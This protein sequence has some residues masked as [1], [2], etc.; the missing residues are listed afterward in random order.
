ME[1][2]KVLDI[3]RNYHNSWVNKNFEKAG[4]F[5]AENL[6]VIVPINN[7]PTKQS[8]LAAV[9][10]TVTMV[11]SIELLSAFNN[12]NEAMIMYDMTLNN[13]SK[14]RIAEH[15]LIRDEKIIQICQIHDTAPFVM[16]PA[17]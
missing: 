6:S 12:E 2:S 13:L 8:F 10:Y 9:E 5:L 14:L 7:Y 11:N 1:K 4:S 16:G 15:F 17:K 3:V